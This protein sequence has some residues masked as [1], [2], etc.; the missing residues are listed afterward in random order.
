VIS[1]AVRLLD[2]IWDLV[3][4][5]HRIH[6][7]RVGWIENQASFK[8]LFI[9]NSLNL[10]QIYILPPLAVLKLPFSRGCGFFIMN[11]TTVLSFVSCSQDPLDIL[12]PLSQDTEIVLLL[13]S[14]RMILGV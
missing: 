13:F 14:C 9:V 6:Q 1:D 10:V 3:C 4:A 7:A 2:V 5:R 11:N 12:P 8:E